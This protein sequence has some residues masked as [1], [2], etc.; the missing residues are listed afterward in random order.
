MKKKMNKN[1]LKKPMV[2]I[3]LATSIG[4]PCLSASGSA[5]AVENTPTSV[6]ENV[7]VG[8]TDVKS[9]LKKIGEYYYTN[10]Y[11]GKKV[12][13]R[14]YELKPRSVETPVNL[15]ITGTVNK[16]NFESTTPEYIGENV[17]E[18]TTDQTHKFT[19][20]KF[21]KSVTE[22]TTTT[23]TNGFKVGG[24]GD[25]FTIPVLI[26]GIKVN[27][28][29]NS[30]TTEAK[31]KSETKTLEASSQTIEVPP[32]K[33]YKTD[34]VLEQRAFW[35]DVTF[36]GEA[37]TPKIEINA[38]AYYTAPNGMIDS[39]KYKFSD[40]AGY[41]FDYLT[42][43]QKNSINGIQFKN[44]DLKA[45]GTAKVEGIIGSMLTV[46]VYDITDKSNPK[47]V[48]TRTFK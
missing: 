10:T 27:P 13:H 48:E 29:F 7:K 43:S 19:T 40:C 47:L 21:T 18:N 42:T 25:I 32:H 1:Q 16:L 5:L 14:R 28:E 35:G 38:S 24:S 41:Y 3:M 23:T 45:E 30:S 9:E 34:V 17:F 31:T 15:S 4:I 20:A 2:A 12:E 39:K 6:S 36:T 8:I 22:S 33:V 26:S 44:H 46:K 37:K 11:A